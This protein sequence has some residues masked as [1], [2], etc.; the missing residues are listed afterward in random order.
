MK[1]S[2]GPWRISHNRRE[3]VVK[4]EGGLIATCDAGDYSCGKEEGY[5]NALLISLAP[6]MYEALATTS[7]ILEAMCIG[8]IQPEYRMS[9][10]R[11]AVHIN[12]AILNKLEVT[13]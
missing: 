9:E 1:H 10:M 6:E 8:T 12:R 4:S 2:S 13:P 11:R 5:A 3:A 7:E